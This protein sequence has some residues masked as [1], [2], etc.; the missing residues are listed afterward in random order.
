MV[1]IIINNYNY[2]R[3]LDSAIESAVAQAY[4]PKE[5]VVVDDGSTDNSR[6]VIGTYGERVRAVFQKNSGQA[7]A[8]NAG[9]KASRG[10]ILCFLDSDDWFGAGKIGC[11]VEAF[12]RCGLNSTPMLVHHRLQ[13]VDAV[14]SNLDGQLIGNLHESPLNLY[15]YAKRYK[16]IPYK[17]AP[18]SGLSLNRALADRLFPLPEKGI[19][20]MAD[21]FV[22]KGASLV[23]ELHCLDEVLGFYRLH[24]GNLWHGS[25][26]RKPPGYIR[27]LD[28][29][30]NQ[31]LM[32]NDLSPV[33]DF[34]DSMYSW[35]DL[36][37]DRKWLKWGTQLLTLSVRQHD[38]HT[39][40]YVWDAFRSIGG[41]TLRLLKLRRSSMA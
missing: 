8:F 10:Q 39:S 2:G 11:I 29:Y 4:S 3:F 34:Y 6:D 17:A 14:G 15:A 12:S 19:R 23:G 16:A 26:S 30:L 7:T 20:T 28:A 9:V 13:M 37:A 18:T 27:S 41:L 21:D 33:L 32:E 38:R 25:N 31:R 24:G 22:V 36:F 40:K 5:I 1:S 35:G